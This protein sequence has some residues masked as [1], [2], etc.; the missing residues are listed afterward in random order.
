MPGIGP[1]TVNGI[2]VNANKILDITKE[3]AD[4]LGF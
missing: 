2:V 4:S 3:N 1:L